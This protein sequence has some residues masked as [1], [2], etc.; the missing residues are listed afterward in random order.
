MQPAP[1]VP[2]RPLFQRLAALAQAPIVPAAA[3]APGAWFEKPVRGRKRARSRSR[4]SSP[5]PARDILSDI[6]AGGDGP[7]SELRSSARG[8]SDAEEAGVLHE[9]DEPENTAPRTRRSKRARSEPVVIDA[10]TGQMMDTLPGTEPTE[11]Q[12]FLLEEAE[13]DEQGKIDAMILEQMDK[14]GVGESLVGR[15]VLCS[16][17]NRMVDAGN[18]GTLMYNEMVRLIEMNLSVMS[19]REIVYLIRRFYEHQ[20]RP[21]YEMGGMGHLLPAFS[22]AAVYALL[23]SSTVHSMTRR[24]GTS[25]LRRRGTRS[26]GG[27]WWPSRFARWTLSPRW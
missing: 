15:C 12:F 3:P 4:S 19:P 11:L 23:L 1:H 13:A 6:M 25:T 8:H 7:D 27:C 2:G 17:G 14:D 5:A 20:M 10:V 24:P 26:T 9:G 21:A 16:H 22:G 18:M